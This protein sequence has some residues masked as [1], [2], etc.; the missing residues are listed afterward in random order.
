[1]ASQ[2]AVD[3]VKTIATAKMEFDFLASEFEQLM[4][5]QMHTTAWVESINGTTKNYAETTGNTM[6]SEI[7]ELADTARRAWG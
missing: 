6:A 7:K 5:R 3:T 2:N 1:M 4:D